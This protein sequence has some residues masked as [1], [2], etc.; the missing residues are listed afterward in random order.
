MASRSEGDVLIILILSVLVGPRVSLQ[1]ILH[2]LPD[3]HVRV[4]RALDRL[5]GKGICPSIF[6]QMLLN[7]LT[8]VRLPTVRRNW[9]L[10]EFQSD[11]AS[12]VIRNAEDRLLIGSFQESL[13]LEFLCL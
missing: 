1:E 2:C 6:L 9:V 3:G 12:E 4:N 8:L 5:S 13:H 10:H 7:G 11:P